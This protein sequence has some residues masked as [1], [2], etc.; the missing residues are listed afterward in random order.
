[1]SVPQ[2]KRRKKLPG[3]WN[4][5]D[6]VLRLHRA[7]PQ[8]F[9]LLH[10]A[11]H[12]R[13]APTPRAIAHWRTP[14]TTTRQSPQTWMRT[15]W[16]KEQ[17]TEKYV[18]TISKSFDILRTQ[19]SAANLPPEEVLPVKKLHFF[20]LSVLSRWLCGWGRLAWTV[21]PAHTLSR[22]LPAIPKSTRSTPPA[23]RH[24]LFLRQFKGA[25]N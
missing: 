12:I 6:V 11:L 16:G 5:R 25:S 18:L 13:T 10:P 8:P 19:H 14:C 24:S 3:E 1:M 15:L 23:R 22:K 2:A 20:L 17:V 4:H 9:W 21:H 7:A